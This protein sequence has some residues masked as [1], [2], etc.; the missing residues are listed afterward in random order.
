VGYYS[1]QRRINGT[2]S[3]LAL[4]S[5]QPTFDRYPVLN[6]STRKSL[7]LNFNNQMY[8]IPYTIWKPGSVK[9]DQGQYVSLQFDWNAITRDRQGQ[10]LF[11]MERGDNE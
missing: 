4:R 9:I 7:S 5:S 1:K 8:N 2:M 10:P 6:S 3:V 11:E